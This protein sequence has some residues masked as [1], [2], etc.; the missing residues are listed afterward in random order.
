MFAALVLITPQ[1]ARGDNATPNDAPRSHRVQLAT[2]TPAS[3]G[4]EYIPV[5]RD[6]GQF[7]QLRIELSHGHVYL[8]TVAVRFG[9]GHVQ[10]VAIERWLDDAHPLATFDLARASWIDTVIVTTDRDAHG[11]YA[12][13]ATRP[14]PTQ[15]AHAGE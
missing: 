2:P 15:V 14:Q 11:S 4:T 12:V 13:F 7:A 1:P 3:N 5:G 6:S 9:D 8:T 10:T